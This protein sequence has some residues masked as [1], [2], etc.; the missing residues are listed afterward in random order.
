MGSVHAD[1]MLLAA[2]HPLERF[3]HQRR[4]YQESGFTAGMIIV[5]ALRVVRVALWSDQGWS[6]SS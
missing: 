3:G 4:S 1:V 2:G 6:A 5:P